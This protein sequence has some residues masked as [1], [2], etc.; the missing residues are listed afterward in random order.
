MGI[1]NGMF[2]IGAQ[3]RHEKGRK[4]EGGEEGERGGVSGFG[5][6]EEL[7]FLQGLALP[8]LFYLGVAAVVGDIFLGIWGLI[9]ITRESG[10]W[11]S[12]LMGL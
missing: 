7:S 2:W 6:G 10:F 4:Q 12:V 3:L 1:R 5:E 11:G 8:D 9:F